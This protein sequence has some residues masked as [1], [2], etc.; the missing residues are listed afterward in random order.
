MHGISEIG[1]M[2]KNDKREPGKLYLCATPIGNLED[3]TLRAVRILK[4]ADLI[5]AEDTRNTLRL[6][7]HFDIHTPLT[8]YHEYNKYDKANELAA[9]MLEGRTVALVTD[10]GMPGISDPGE[11]LVRISMEAGIT[12]SV[13]PGA[14]ACVSALAISGL[15]TRRFCFEGFLPS[16]KKE[17]RER[18][19]RLRDETRT[20]ILYEAPHRLKGTLRELSESLGER[21]ISIC[22]ELTKI[23]EEVLPLSLSEA[24][25]YYESHEP[26][27]EFVLVVE[28]RSEQQLRLKEQSSWEEM[29]L[30]R[31]MQMYL[32]EGMDRKEAMKAV[33]RDRGVPRRE[34]YER[35][36]RE[37]KDG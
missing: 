15:P 11:E 35:L 10:A 26:K 18:L 24:A 29:P 17:R 31:H 25:R 21:R 7:N 27:G 34:I 36:L 33:A 3:M 19:E 20:I 9:R 4:E 12:V 37:E 5:A 22:R 2:E 13:V 6:L 8:S 23:H 30:S 1:S 14:C 28:G 32:S 16:V